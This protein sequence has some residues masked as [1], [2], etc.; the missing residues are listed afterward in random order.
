MAVTRR[1]LRN[2]KWAITAFFLLLGLATLAAY[3]K[4]GIA[5]APLYGEPYVPASIATGVHT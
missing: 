1:R 4:I 3:I 5:H 2:F